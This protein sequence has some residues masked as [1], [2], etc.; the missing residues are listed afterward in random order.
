MFTKKYKLEQINKYY[1]FNSIW[2][3]NDLIRAAENKGSHFFDKGAMKFFKSHILN[4]IF[5]SK[6]GVYFVTSEKK[7]FNDNRRAFTVRF[8]NRKDGDIKTI[9][10]FGGYDTKA[11]ALTGAL[12]CAYDGLDREEQ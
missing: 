10:E 6:N 2:S 9:S 7:G 8:Y 5:P 11:T 4:D 3:I 12:N 1:V